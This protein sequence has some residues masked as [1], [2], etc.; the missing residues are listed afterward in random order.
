MSA[1][2]LSS[3]LIVAILYQAIHLASLFLA[4]VITTSFISYLILYLV[5][6]ILLTSAE[7]FVEQ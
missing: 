6:E 4:F 7:S 3:V 2:W 5:V 1:Y